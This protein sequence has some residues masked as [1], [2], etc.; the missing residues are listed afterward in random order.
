M[1]AI[2]RQLWLTRENKEKQL[3]LTE[4]KK[5]GKKDGK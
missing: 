5:K 1:K 4:G 3:I 2:M